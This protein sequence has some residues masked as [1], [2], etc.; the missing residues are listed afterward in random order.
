MSDKGR[1]IRYRNNLV[2]RREYNLQACLSC[3]GIVN[4]YLGGQY[5][6]SVFTIYQLVK[7]TCSNCGRYYLELYLT[8]SLKNQSPVFTLG[9][10]LWIKEEKDSIVVL[11]EWRFGCPISYLFDFKQRLARLK[12]ET[13]REF[14]SQQKKP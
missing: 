12:E 14:E 5:Y 6:N 7:G 4:G 8:V 9:F 3:G 1:S 11:T 2:S 13:K 10:P